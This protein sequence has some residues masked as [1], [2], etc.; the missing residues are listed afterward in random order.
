MRITF[1]YDGAGAVSHVMVNPAAF[2]PCMEPIAERV[3][4][5]E[6]GANREIGTYNLST[7]P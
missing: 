5:P 3:R 7:T 4:L 6:S 1:R 2:Q